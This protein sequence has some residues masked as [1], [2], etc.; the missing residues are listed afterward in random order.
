MYPRRPPDP[1]SG[2]LDLVVRTENVYDLMSYHVLDGLSCRLQVLARIEVRWILGKILTDVSCHCETDIRIDVD[3]ADC[4][5]CCLT[6]LLLRDADSIRHVS[7]VFVD[8]L[9]EFLR[10]G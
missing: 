6:E 4:R 5:S 2:F 3:L 10:Y 7:A 9:Y 8:H 1:F